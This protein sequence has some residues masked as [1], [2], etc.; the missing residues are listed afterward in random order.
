MAE[1]Q[2]ARPRLRVLPTVLFAL[3]LVFAFA[4]AIPV[5]AGGLSVIGQLLPMA[6]LAAIG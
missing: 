6:V 3:L 2:N 4:S 5:P 1:T